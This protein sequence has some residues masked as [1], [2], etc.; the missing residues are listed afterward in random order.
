M[1]INEFISWA[2]QNP[3]PIFIYMIIV[4]AAAFIATMFMEENA[5]RS[6]GKYIFSILMYAT[7]VPGVMAFIMTGYSLVMKRADLMNFNILVYFLPI[8]S[9]LL[10]I[11]VIQRVIRMVDIP[12][13]KRLS[14]FI[15]M[16][17]VTC[18]LVFILQRVF[19]GVFFFG[20][21]Q[22]L[23]LLF[24]VLFVVIKIGWDRVS[25]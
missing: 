4:P 11:G 2:D 21:L 1:T 3:V 16:I 7:C 15:M 22:S 18:I 19:I 14:G 5:E 8:V 25:A 12:G 17:G 20:T 23:L 10:T 6:R 9:M 24:V 13:F